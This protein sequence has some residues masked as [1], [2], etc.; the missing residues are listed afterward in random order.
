MEIN[1]ALAWHKNVDPKFRVQFL[2]MLENKKFRDAR[3]ERLPY[4]KLVKIKLHYL[5]Q[6]RNSLRDGHKIILDAWNNEEN[7]L[8][9]VNN[10]LSENDLHF[11]AMIQAGIIGRKEYGLNIESEHILI[12][13]SFL[14]YF[15]L[16]RQ[17]PQ[18]FKTN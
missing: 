7:N 13:F 5:K 14:Q 8:L 15:K 4:G 3:K 16:F 2:A 6:L 1:E 11:D 17:F 12:R 9:T 10:K 18:L